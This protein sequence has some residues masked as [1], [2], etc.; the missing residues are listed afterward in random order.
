MKNF[1]NKEKKKKEKKRAT[2]NQEFLT[3]IE[4]ALI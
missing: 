1:N 2:V 4:I 3:V